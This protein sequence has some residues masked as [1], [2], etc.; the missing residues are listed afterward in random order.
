MGK[1]AFKAVR[2]LGRQLPTRAG[3]HADHHRCCEL[4]ARHVADGGGGVHDLIQRQQAEI[5]RHDLDDRAHS[6][7]GRP[8]SRAGEAGFRQRRVADARRAEFGQHA[9]GDRIAAAIRPHI[10][11]HQEHAFV[12]PHRLGE[13]SAHRLAVG[14]FDGFAAWG[15]R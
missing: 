2:M 10:L 13:G 7:H 8:N 9:F 4:T 5:H 3:G 14:G 1:P 15:R 6:D 12:A 11:A